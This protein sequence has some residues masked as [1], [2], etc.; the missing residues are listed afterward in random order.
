MH[1]EINR[2]NKWVP[3]TIYADELHREPETKSI[4]THCVYNI[5]YNL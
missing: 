4:G 3:F 1:I 5:Y 2:R